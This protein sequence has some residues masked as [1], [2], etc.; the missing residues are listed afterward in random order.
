MRITLN[1]SLDVQALHTS[2][3]KIQKKPKYSVIAFS[4]EEILLSCFGG[5]EVGGGQDLSPGFPVQLSSGDVVSARGDGD[6]C[7]DHLMMIY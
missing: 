4:A 3:K 1:I 5:D 6:C 2:A 7:P